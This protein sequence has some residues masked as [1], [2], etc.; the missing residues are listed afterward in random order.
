MGKRM[1]QTLEEPLSLFHYNLSENN[2][3]YVDKDTY[4]LP[5]GLKG[6]LSII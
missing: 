3:V 6:V 4:E 2:M 5:T 1:I